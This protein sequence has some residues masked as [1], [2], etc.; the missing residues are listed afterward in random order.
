MVEEQVVLNTPLQ[1]IILEELSRAL[2]ILD[3]G[4]GGEGLVSRI[5]GRR[6]CAVDYRISEIREAQIHNPPSNWFVADGRDLPFKDNAFDLATLWFSLGYMTDN[7][8][9]KQV[10]KEAF[11]SLKQN[12]LI[13]IMACRI[14]CQEERFVFQ[15]LFT[16][17]DGALSKVGYGVRGGQNQTV[18]GIASLL[19]EAG[20][21]I[22]QVEDH[23]SWFT[24]KASKR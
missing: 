22:I 11:R 19:E 14:V 7:S 8:I 20:F 1:N 4:G 15:A 24:I 9:K 5:A 2:I 23:D 18:T 16:L 12:G 17:P 10:L 13:S 21:V 3:I 6:V